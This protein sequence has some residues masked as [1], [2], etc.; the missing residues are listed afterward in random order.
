[1]PTTKKLVHPRILASGPT[2]TPSSLWHQAWP[3]V[4]GRF[5]RGSGTVLGW[6]WCGSRAA[7]G[8]LAGGSRAALEEVVLG[9]VANDSSGR[10]PPVTQCKLHVILRIYT[11]FP[12]VGL[13]LEAYW[14]ARHELSQT[15]SSL[16]AQA[17][18]Q[19]PCRL[20]PSELAFHSTEHLHFR[21][22]SL[23]IWCHFCS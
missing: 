5:W 7:R 18:S 6:F 21:R 12:L 23:H 22:P 14:R 15:R 17:D 19:V 13:G 2:S 16:D 4:C 9:Q 1:M 11:G 20:A 3:P 10:V 8:R